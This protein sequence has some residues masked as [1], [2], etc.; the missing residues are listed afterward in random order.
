MFILAI[1]EDGVFSAKP[2]EAD[3]ARSFGLIGLGLVAFVGVVCFI[4]DLPTYYETYLLLKQTY[5]DVL[6]YLRNI[7]KAH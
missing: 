7:Q 4:T 5:A 3:N 1:S 2:T 6:Y